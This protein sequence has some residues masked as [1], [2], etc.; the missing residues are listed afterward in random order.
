VFETP[1]LQTERLTLREWRETDRAPFAAMNA[2]PTVMEHF[3]KPLAPPESDAMIDRAMENWAA[4]GPCW[5]ALEDL[6]G[7]FIGFT[8][9]YKPTFETH[10]TPCVEIGWRLTKDA[11]GNGYATESS[12]AAMTWGFDVLALDEIV[13]FTVPQNARSRRVME[14]LRMTYDPTD[15]WDH[16]RMAEIPRMQR[17][18][19]YRMQ[20]KNWMPL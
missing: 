3:P 6:N 4:G 10:F 1:V 16:P 13:S 11:W 19:L 9:L 7:E 15:D 18:V 2:D 14:R 8:G 17:H 5:W 20:S 12:T